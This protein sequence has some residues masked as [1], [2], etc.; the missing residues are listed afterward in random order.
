MVGSLGQTKS[1]LGNTR[2][3]LLSNALFVCLV[4]LSADG[5]TRFEPPDVHELEERPER[6]IGPELRAVGRFASAGAGRLRL[7]GSRI[8]FRLGPEAR[9]Y[10]NPQH[11]S[12]VGK[13]LRENGKLVF[14]ITSLVKIPPDSERF[15]QYRSRI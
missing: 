6:F 13:L 2:M 3:R 9:V 10:S 5:A 14:Q 1:C 11:V 7:V 4:G 15:A 8:D 12:L